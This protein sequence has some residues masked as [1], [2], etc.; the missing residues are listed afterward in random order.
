[1]TSA[2]KISIPIS[3]RN[4][5]YLLSLRTLKTVRGLPTNFASK[6]AVEEQKYPDLLKRCGVALDF[7]NG[8]ALHAKLMK[9][10]LLSSLFLHNHLLNMYV[11]WGD[12]DQACKLFDEMTQ[13]NV[14]SWS[15][16][17]TG[18]VQQGFYEKGLSY[19]C[20]M[21]RAGCKPNEFTFV[22]SL[23]ACS[24]IEDS[25]QMYQLYCLIIQLGFESNVFLTN[26]FLS[27]LFR[28]K[29]LNEAMELFEKC[30]GRDIVSWNSMIGGFLQMSHSEIP[31]F[32]CRMNHERVEPDNFT[33]SSILTGLAALSNLQ[34]GLQVHAQLV[35]YGHLDE[36]CVGNSL[37]DM[38]LKC[39]KFVEALRVFNDMPHKDVLTWT[40]MASGCLQCGEPS[41][42][43]EIIARMRKFGVKPNRFTLAAAFNA[44]ATLPSVEEGKKVH[45]LRIKLGDEADVAADNALLDMYAKCGSMED[46][47]GVFWSMDDKSVVSWTTMIMGLAQNGFARAAL[48]LF[49]RMILEE[50]V[51]NYITLVCVLHAC[52]QGGFID[53]GWQYLSSMTHK[54]GIVPGEDHYACMVLLL[55][56]LGQVKEAE[57]FIRRMPIQPGLLVW[58]TLLG[59][60]SV[61]GDIETAKIAA[62][63]ALSL[64]KGDP[65][66]YVLLSNT[67][68]DSS[69]WDDASKLRKL[70]KNTDVKKKPG[71]SWIEL[72]GS[73]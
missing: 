72:A 10:S 13:R 63:E 54:Y 57:D 20:L 69:N 42:A 21:H 43:L 73:G 62:K 53:E 66:T 3:F 47:W 35:K 30:P 19:F 39:Q 32:W 18:L 1:M 31:S 44:C 16:I 59:A 33:F 58:Q 36:I 26:A 60:C 65:S 70:M 41:E 24:F 51:P 29:K 71:Y 50:A 7:N 17:I 27:A 49:E 14:V 8:K 6:L 55:G 37:V 64:D 12:A 22:S 34:M 25:T 2:M 15:S 40:E 23:N 48:E 56:R 4:T 68:A 67:Y 38:Y 61:H 45:G 52:G 28:H 5:N 11:K 46:A 9:E